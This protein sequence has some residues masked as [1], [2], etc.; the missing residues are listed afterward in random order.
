MGI[1]RRFVL[2]KWLWDMTPE[3]K[4][5]YESI[6]KKKP[7]KMSDKDWAELKHKISMDIFNRIMPPE[8]ERIVREKVKPV[9][10]I[11]KTKDASK[12]ISSLLPAESPPEPKKVRSDADRSSSGKNPDRSGLAGE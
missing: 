1:A 6:F 9:P 10:V 5:F 11:F 2:E 4:K 12:D 7:E 8:K 3:L